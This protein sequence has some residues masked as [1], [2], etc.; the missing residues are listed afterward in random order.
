MGPS[1]CL[2]ILPE[3]SQELH[4]NISKA[5]SGITV[6]YSARLCL[7]VNLEIFVRILFS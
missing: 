7:A 3:P 2:K 5:E 4:L 6:S 1:L